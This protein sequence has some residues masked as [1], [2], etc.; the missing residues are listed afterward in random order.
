MFERNYH[1]PSKENK[2]CLY[3]IVELDSNNKN[4]IKNKQ[5]VRDSVTNSK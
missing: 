1:K 2:N 5:F 4:F 3:I